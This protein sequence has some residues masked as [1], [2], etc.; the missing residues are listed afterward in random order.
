MKDKNIMTGSYTYQELLQ[1]YDDFETPAAA[2]YVGEDKV[3]VMTEKDIVITGIQVRLSA[4]ETALLHFEVMDAYDMVSHSFQQGIRDCFAAGTLIE[5]ALGYG[6]NLTTIFKGYITECKSRYGEEIS[7]SVSALDLRDLMRKNKR[8]NY[9]YQEK[10]YSEVFEELIGSYSSLYDT[11]HVDSVSE[12]AALMQSSSDYDFV[13]QELCRRGKRS[14]FVVGGEVYFRETGKEE[15]AFLELEW[16]NGILSF[17]KGIRYC[18]EQIS[19]YSSQENK[20]SLSVS[21][22]LKTEDNTPA[23]LSDTQVEEWELGVGLNQQI[24]QNY[25]DQREEEKTEKNIVAGGSLIGLPEVVPGRYLKISGLDSSDAGTYYIQEVRHEYGEDGFV[26]GFTVGEADDGWTV[27]L[28]SEENAWNRQNGLMRA[29]VKENWNEEHPGCV[30]V[31]LLSGTEG[32]KS[33]QWLPVMQPY[34]GNSY[35]IY[36]LPEIDTEVLVGSQ[37]GDMN[38]LLVLGALWNQSDQLPADT[39]V[40][41]NTI[42][43]IRTK[44]GHEIFFDEA[45]ESA[46]LT[47]H[48]A[49]NLCISMM[50]KEKK[51]LISDAEGKN[52]LCLDGDQGTMELKAD[53]KLSMSVGGKDMLELNADA[54]KLAL[55]ADHIVEKGQQDLNIQ[56]QNLSVKGEMT[57]L[58]AR[59]SFKINS[60]GIA[61][62]KGTMV[63]IN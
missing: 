12:K 1:A 3:N 27:P 35:G 32:R 39:A 59:A 6:S 22:Q 4:R 15:S 9:K 51:I 19:V 49:E 48:T 17:E 37:M 34:C 38:S 21:V 20:S 52:T 61:E 31:E 36:F 58:K 50:E 10:T 14:F 57:E 5:A 62:I 24:L 18:N 53:K 26:T 55:T 42:K 45:E 41:E 29:V 16:G 60:S 7:L 28:V 30:L 11:L 44:G 33:S 25:L 8:V 47:M 2:I 54:G 13:T 56:T 43:K 46:Q 40:E 23:L 63:K